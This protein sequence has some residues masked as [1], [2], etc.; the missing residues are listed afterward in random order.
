MLSRRAR[1]LFVCSLLACAASQTSPLPKHPPL[2]LGQLIP[3]RDM[4]AAR[5]GHTATVL[6]DFRVLIVGGEQGG[7]QEHGVIL[8]S[9]EFYDPNTEKFSAAGKMSVPRE[10]HIAAV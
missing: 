10:G 3:G 5:A 9:A 2:P 8:A 1:F 4:T 7:R 6:P